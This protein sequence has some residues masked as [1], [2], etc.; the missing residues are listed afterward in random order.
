MKLRTIQRTAFVNVEHN[1]FTR[2]KLLSGLEGRI[3]HAQLRTCAGGVLS[4]LSTA[5]QEAARCGL[6]ATSMLQDGS[7]VLADD[8]VMDMAGGAAQMAEAEELLV[9]CLAKPS[10]IATAAS[11]AVRLADG[12]VAVVCG[13]WKKMP[14][15]IKAPVREAILH[16]GASFRISSTPMIYLDKNYLRMFGSIGAALNAARR[17]PER[18]PVV[19]LR[20]EAG[21]MAA[22]TAEA[23]EGG[24]KVLM[25]DTGDP[26]DIAPCL[27][28][29][30]RCGR[31]N[32]CRVA[33][34][35]GV[36]LDA[37]DSLASTGI[38]ILCIGRAIVDAPLLDMRL[39]VEGV[40]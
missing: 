19:Q 37:V 18:F 24:A 27:D 40:A 10:G 35:G 38:D 28:E 9:G 32:D 34:A 17:F 33:F 20:K 12:L 2:P 36:E 39:D 22:Q 31:R 15:L 11:Q 1:A 7:E 29:L 16:G 3:F 25:I 26:A 4:G 6:K 13:A 5:L 23:L 21:S 30:Q 8:I 14:P